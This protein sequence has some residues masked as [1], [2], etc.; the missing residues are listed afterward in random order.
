VQVD[1]FDGVGGM[2]VVMYG[3]IEEGLCRR[4]EGDDGLVT[5]RQRKEGKGVTVIIMR[6]DGGE[7]LGGR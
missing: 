1:I 7:K 3:V 4:Y 2:V 6:E 5:G